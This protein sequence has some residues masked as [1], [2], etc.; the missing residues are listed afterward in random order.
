MKFRW[1]PAL[2]Q[3]LLAAQLP[4]TLKL[5]PLLVQCLLNCGLSKPAS[6][7]GSLQPRLKQLAD[8]LLNGLIHRSARCQSKPAAPPRRRWCNFA[9]HTGILDCENHSYT[10]DYP[11]R[12]PGLKRAPLRAANIQY[13]RAFGDEWTCLGNAPSLQHSVNVFHAFGG[14]RES[15]FS[16]RTLMKKLKKTIWI[17]TT[18][19]VT[20]GI[21]RRI[22][23][24]YDSMP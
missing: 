18:M 20:A 5:P 16:P 9:L 21:N 19:S 14:R 24:P 22:L 4:D 3:L 7:T 11:S 10:A 13:P 6:I 1:S 23:S 2:P 17:A 15:V 12:V 8:P